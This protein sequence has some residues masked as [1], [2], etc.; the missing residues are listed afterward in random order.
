[1]LLCKT[2]PTQS[3]LILQPLDS[4]TIRKSV[5]YLIIPLLLVYQIDYYE[6]NRYCIAIWPAQS[7]D[8]SPKFC[9]LCWYPFNKAM[10]KAKPPLSRSDGQ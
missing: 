2:F 8:P 10:P 9:D 7:P 4:T 1:V 3:I 5:K 6:S